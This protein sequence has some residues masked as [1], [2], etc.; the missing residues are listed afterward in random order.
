MNNT[1]KY[2]CC[3]IYSYKSQSKKKEKLTLNDDNIES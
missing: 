1:F 3:K 2:H